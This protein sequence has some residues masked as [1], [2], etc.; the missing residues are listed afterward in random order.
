L[1]FSILTCGIYYIYLMYKLGKLEAS[2]YYSVGWQ[3][4][5]SVLYVILTIFGLSLVTMG[6]VQSN[7]NYLATHGDN[8]HDDGGP[9]TWPPHG[10]GGSG[11]GGGHGNGLRPPGTF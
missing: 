7:L 3:K 8:P 9:G 2:A 6:I 5:D 11:S 4:D 1:V 10:G